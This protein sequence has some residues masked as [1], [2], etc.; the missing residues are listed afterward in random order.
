MLDTG[1]WIPDVF[2]FSPHVHCRL[3]SIEYLS[4]EC[5]QQKLS[6]MPGRKDFK[7][8]QG[9]LTDSSIICHIQFSRYF[10]TAF[11]GAGHRAE[12][13]MEFMHFPCSFTLLGI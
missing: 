2:G 10:N 8:R 6:C 3:S 1:F 11:E 4:E 9:K 13:R 7:Q 12:I 5:S